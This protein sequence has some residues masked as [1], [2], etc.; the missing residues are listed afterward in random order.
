VRRIGRHCGRVWHLGQEPPVRSA[1][2]QRAVGLSIDLKALF[3]DCAVVPAAEQHE[4]RERGGTALGPVPD[5]MPLAEADAAAREAAAA[6][7]MLERPA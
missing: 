3:V 2:S 7:A 4:I 5:V 6:V 1:K